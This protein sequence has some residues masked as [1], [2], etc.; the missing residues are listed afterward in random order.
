MYC[1]DGK[2]LLQVLSVIPW[3][4][5]FL[6]RYIKHASWPSTAWCAMYR[7]IVIRLLLHCI[8]SVKLCCLWRNKE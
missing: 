4:S 8:V 5:S 2:T 1:A 7:L 6:S 3:Q